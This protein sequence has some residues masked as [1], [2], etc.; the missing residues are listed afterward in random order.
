MT[1]ML[2]ASATALTVVS[3]I[4][5]VYR[6][7]QRLLNFWSRTSFFLMML[8]SLPT[9]SK[10]CSERLSSCFAEAVQLLGLE[11]WLKKTEVVYQP[12][13]REEY[14]PPYI[15]IGDNELKTVYQFT[16]P[17]CTITSD[18][19]IDRE[20]DNRLAKANSSNSILYKRVWKEKQQRNCTKDQCVQS[21]RSYKPTALFTNAASTPSCSSTLSPHHPQHSLER[22]RHHCR[23]FGTGQDHQH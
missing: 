19:K 21:L 23:R 16:S 7:T 8:P 9:V 20:V 22:L 5:E 15:T 14:H 12:A 18:T 3:L 4:S 6:P 17:R 11:V 1:A 2:Y 13:T 10:P